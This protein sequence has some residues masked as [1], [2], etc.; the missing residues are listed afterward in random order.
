MGL[1]SNGCLAPPRSP[2]NL[3]MAFRRSPRLKGSD[4]ER[5]GEQIIRSTVHKK[6]RL[7][8]NV[9]VLV[10]K[11]DQSKIADIRRDYEL[12]IPACRHLSRSPITGK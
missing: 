6:E 2:A 10:E 11:M 3:L 8:C 12:T 9:I 7:T 5:E 1:R 4:W